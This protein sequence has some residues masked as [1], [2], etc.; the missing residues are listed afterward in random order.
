MNPIC[1][2]CMKPTKTEQGPPEAT[3]W[4]GVSII[5]KDGKDWNPNRSITS[6]QWK[7]LECGKVWQV[8]NVP[9]E[10]ENE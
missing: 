4:H 5:D 9:E 2:D 8:L 3:L 6:S 7:C 1:P 10:K